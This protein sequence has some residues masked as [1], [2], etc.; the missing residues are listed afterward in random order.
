MRMK[1]KQPACRQKLK[2]KQPAAVEKRSEE[3]V[4]PNAV[5][6]IP[7]QDARVAAVRIRTVP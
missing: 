7:V 5:Y 4:S 3:Q 1:R 6:R 2:A